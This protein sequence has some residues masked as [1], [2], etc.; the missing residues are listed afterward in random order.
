M[1]INKILTPL[2]LTALFLLP[3]PPA[4]GAQTHSIVSWNIQYFGKTKDVGE[5]KAI[6]QIVRDFDI[7]LIQEVVRIDPNG[8]RKVGE[9]A[10]LLKRMG[11]NLDYPVSDFTDSPGKRKE[12][13]A[14]L[15]KPSRLKLIGRPL[16]DKSCESVM[17]REPYLARFQVNGESNS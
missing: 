11:D 9:L 17:Y 4:L 1:K 6:A 12:R 10:E 13:Y 5:L 8:A 3:L 2:F 16:L 15:W 7:V 14:I